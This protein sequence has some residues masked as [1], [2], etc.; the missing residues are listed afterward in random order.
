MKVGDI[1]TTQGRTITETD[2]VNYVGLA[3]LFDPLFINREFATKQSI[4]GKPI[5]PGPLTLV[6][7]TGLETLTGFPRYV[8]AFLGMDQV[9]ALKPVFINDTIHLDVEV[10]EKFE[11][12]RPD[13]GITVV[14]Y[15]TRNQNGELVFTCLLTRMVAKRP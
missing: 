13:S 3:G 7:S 15:N 1:F 5:I 2:L 12:R 9:R 14:K 8:I 6:M 11:T 10:V 4:F